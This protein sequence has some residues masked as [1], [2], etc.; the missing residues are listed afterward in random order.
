MMQHVPKFLDQLIGCIGY[1]TR[2]TNSRK[3]G[4]LLLIELGWIT[5]K[6]PDGVLGGEILQGSMRHCSLLNDSLVSAQRHQES[7]HPS[8]CSCVSLL[9]DLLVD[10]QAIRA[11]L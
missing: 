9:F 2:L 1:L 7:I 10:L 11:S 5:H 6:Q 4:L 3:S 8:I